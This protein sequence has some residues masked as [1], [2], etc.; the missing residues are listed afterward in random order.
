MAARSHAVLSASSSARWLNCPPS[1]RL[2]EEIEDVTSEFAAEGTDAHALCEYKLRKALGM[3]NGEKYP[4]LPSYNQEMEDA[5]T[6][7]VAYVLEVVNEVKKPMALIEQRL[8][9]SRYVE[10]GFGTG[11]CVIV[12][13][14]VLHVIDYKY[15]KGVQVDADHNPQMML[16]ALGAIELF[17]FLFDIKKVSMTIY[18]PRIGNVSTY[19]MATKAL[20][21]WAENTLAPIAKLAYAGKGEFKCGDHCRFC[22][23]KAQCRERAE[24]NMKLASLDFAK[25]PVLQDNEVEEILAKV[26][27]LV[28]WANDIKEYALEAALKGKRWNDWK[29]VEGRSNR[30]YA[31]ENKVAE[32][33][34]SVGLDPFE[35]KLLSVTELQKRI[36][37]AH[38]DDLVAPYVMKPPGKPTLVPRSDKR[39]E[40]NSAAADF[41]DEI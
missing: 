35:K 4:T 23:V 11:D 2:S 22:K 30:K 27:D 25:A 36:G 3:A 17:G 28:S 19:E 34:T 5:A 20:I 31:D 16:Y 9:F 1:A 37:K 13:D 10:E 14:D 8:D 7:Y 15:G 32:V 24:N 33:V 12:S 18:Q 39:E 40:I 41:N 6:D 38:F 21:E 29:I 26:D